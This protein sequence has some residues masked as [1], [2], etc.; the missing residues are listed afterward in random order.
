M[1][2]KPSPLL[3]GLQVFGLSAFVLAPPILFTLTNSQMF[4]L[5]HG[6]APMDVIA[7]GV[8]LT[9][10]IP[11]TLALL[12][13]GVTRVRPNT[14]VPI[15]AL[16]ST[17][18]FSFFV[19]GL[20]LNA[21]A[22]PV[23]VS[24]SLSV[25]IGATASYVTLRIPK[26]RILFTLLAP[27]ALIT[28]G[29]FIAQSEIV[30]P[31][32]EKQRAKIHSSTS[33]ETPVFM[34]ILDEFSTQAL[35]D[36]ERNIDA[37]HFPNFARLAREGVWFRNAT[38]VA[39]FTIN[40]VPAILTGRYTTEPY[41]GI[42]TYHNYPENLFTI[43][44]GAGF[45]V[46]AYEAFTRLCP[47][48]INNRDLGYHLNHAEKL[49]NIFVDVA[50]IGGHLLLPEILSNELPPV[51][52]RI[53]HFTEVARGLR[54][55]QEEAL[56][57]EFF[58]SIDTS[59]KRLYLLHIIMP[60]DPY[61]RLPS[62]QRY[63]RGVYPNPEKI[64][65]GEGYAPSPSAQ[66]RYMLMV[67]YADSLVGRLIDKLVGLGIYDDSIVIVLADHGVSFRQGFRRRFAIR[68][69]EETFRNTDSAMD[70]FKVPLFVKLPDM[71]MGATRDEQIQTIDI[72]PT[73]TGALGIDTT[74]FFDGRD[75][76]AAEVP[77]LDTYR[78]YSRDKR[79]FG[80]HTLDVLSPDY[81]A[82]RMRRTLDPERLY[83]VR[84][85]WDDLI[86]DSLT[87]LG[88][89]KTSAITVEFRAV[90]EYARVDID[91]D[92]VPALVR[93]FAVN[94]GAGKDVAIALNETIV[95]IA[96]TV[97]TLLENK[98]FFQTVIDPAAFK[99]GR[100]SL[101]AFEIRADPQGLPQLLRAKT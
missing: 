12:V 48:S 60:H 73:V 54:K 19:A 17:T 65:G 31:N 50:V 28:L 32:N 10:L 98:V 39:E 42:P 43:L 21:P 69:G 16:V 1:Q 92:Y 20:L 6:A 11:L 34:I 23:L 25:I 64:V 81:D 94:Y 91:S 46:F 70:I 67:Q 99:Q 77:T 75:L 15:W 52:G 90:K 24:L 41:Y 63:V 2:E 14:L 93:G 7:V 83:A 87:E 57:E 74:A 49:K 18:L 8:M 59:T 29:T 45:E 88:D 37:D 96:R 47:D 55:A 89:I 27:V 36:V 85:Q 38:A 71:T 30:F 95:A 4:F 9:V 53:A 84:S 13:A 72:V 5:V 22:I 3:T 79:E 62:A 51:E 78:Y 33:R 76:F 82:E 80:T 58:N 97:P 40:A 56:I 26:I 68:E 86:G 100:N 66:Q 101:E 44:N 61:F 35:F